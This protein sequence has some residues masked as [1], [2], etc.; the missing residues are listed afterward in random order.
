MIN[1]E[2]LK[3]YKCTPADWRKLLEQPDNQP[4]NPLLPL[5]KDKPP[6]EL[7]KSDKLATF[8][9]TIR[10]RVEAGRQ[11][12]LCNYRT[13]QA[14]DLI[15]NS[16]FRQVNPTLMV[17]FIKNYKGRTTE[18]ITSALKNLGLDPTGMW[19][20]GPVDPKTG[21]PTQV[22]NEPVFL[23]TNIPLV[24]AYL[25]IRLAKLFN[26]RNIIP[27]IKIESLI[28]SDD[29]RTR[30][31]VVTS[32][33][34][35]MAEQYGMRNT[36]RQAA[37]MMLLYSQAMQFTKE[38]WHFEQQCKFAS[39]EDV[40]RENAKEK[41]ENKKPEDA[42][43]STYG[44][45]A[46]GEPNGETKPKKKSLA[47]G[48][49]MVYTVLEGLR[50]DLPH[51]ARA[52]WDF[53]FPQWT[54]NTNT[55]CEYAG[56]WRVLKWKE[57]R[58]NPD[59]YNKTRVGWGVSPW[60]DNNL[61]FFQSVYNYCVMD[62][63]K[64][65]APAELDA[66]DRE[67]F[68]A[69]NTLYNETHGEQSVVVTE[70]RERF[71][72][73]NVGLG[74][75]EYPIWGRFVVA[76]DGTIVYAEPCCY[77]PVIVWRDNG[78]DRLTIDASLALKLMPFQDQVSNLLTQQILCA[79]QNLMN[80]TFVEKNVVDEAALAKM[81]N[82]G[83]SHLRKHNFLL[84][85]SKEFFKRFGPGGISQSVKPFESFKFP[86]MDT[87]GITLSIR[88]LLDLAE[89]V[90]QFSSQEVAQAASH[91]QTKAEMDLIKQSSTNILKFTG[92]PVDD[93]LGAQARQIYEALMAYGDDDFYASIPHETR[94]TQEDLKRLGITYVADPKK[95]DKKVFVRAKRSALVLWAFGHAPAP[96]DRKDN[97]EA[98]RMM[99]EMIHLWFMNNE[100]GMAAMGPEQLIELA[101]YIARL[102]GLPFERPL[103]NASM[104]TEQ[105]KRQAMDSL[106]AMVDAVLTDVKKGMVPILEDIAL[107]KQ[108]LGLTNDPRIPDGGAPPGQGEATPAMAIPA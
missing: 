19:I 97:I 73:K 89:R 95:G 65:V 108:T 104:T 64:A 6:P 84:Y 93:A 83:E 39:E 71:I 49:E 31:E 91:E 63:P 70:H 103:R 38:G 29:D 48:D 58:D 7:S 81:E 94:L 68:L 2:I 55:G 18:E 34:E 3:K 37:F 56:H 8:C 57:I 96:D 25:L 69:S 16:A 5:D 15:W 42:P 85:D 14:L 28:N 9:R 50:Y 90:L 100:M 27:F 66:K 88:T 46:N 22:L 47:V 77:N 10:S 78:D 79:R 106:K 51:P 26:D 54:L 80:L 24:G 13:Y 36:F 105:A 72:P 61:H 17:E 87:N 1:R 107:I 23:A 35:T 53:A 40:A 4:S 98:A 44:E 92:H 59:F 67:A 41:P 62:W 99:S 20:E 102:A 52:Y 75:Y 33:I 32:R 82:M 30:C 21:K 43:D 86:H 60:W 74:D 101:N 76:G 45:T 12:N 11:Y